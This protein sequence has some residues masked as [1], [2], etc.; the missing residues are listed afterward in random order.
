MLSVLKLAC[1]NIMKLRLFSGIWIK[2]RRSKIVI[3]SEDSRT[4]GGDLHPTG[5]LRFGAHLVHCT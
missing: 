2:E 3:K 5:Q 1:L 4:S